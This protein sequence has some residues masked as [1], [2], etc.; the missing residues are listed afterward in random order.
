MIK[1][2]KDLEYYLSQ[3]AAAMNRKGK[4][5]FYGDEIFKFIV[6]MRKLEYYSNVSGGIFHRLGKIYYKLKFHKIS[7]KLGFS[8]PI[9][10][11]EEG[12]AIVHYGYLAV[13]KGAHIGK[14]CRVQTGVIIGATSGESDAPKIGNNVYIGAGAKI[15]GNITV[16][17]NV[18]VGA[19]AVV[20]KSITEPSITVAGVPA[21]KISDH[22]SS[23]HLSKSLK[24]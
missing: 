23:R 16:A 1:S 9:N 17:D 20:V 19:N 5:K 3:D 2:K 12:L 18:A 21:K 8:V 4:P 14:N 15:I 7:V 22:D 24:L 13:S 11:F 6:T 10:A